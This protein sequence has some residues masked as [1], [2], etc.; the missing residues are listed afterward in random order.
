MN[1]IVTKISIKNILLNTILSIIK[2]TAGSFAGSLAVLSDGFNSL[3]DVATTITILISR[4]FTNK[5]SD[6]DHPYGHEKIESMVVFSVAIFLVAVALYTIYQSVL[7]LAG[8]NVITGSL[9]ALVASAFSAIVK[10]YMYHSTEKVAKEIDSDSLR[11]IAADYKFDVFLSMSVFVGVLF[12]MF[13]WWFFEPIAAIVA[14]VILFLSA[15]EFMK[16]AF[17]Q[18]V[19]KA[20]DDETIESIRK[21]VMDCNGVIRIDLIKTRLHGRFI[22]VDIEIS[23]DPDITVKS[24]HSIAQK[25]HDVIEGNKS[26]NVIH[27]NVH[28]NPFED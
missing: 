21:I 4:K 24:G 23:V 7:N 8:K 13:G 18:V 27:C 9:F 28:V 10:F 5:P 25:V 15:A 26:L 3:S 20:A 16:K 22:Y 12:T 2:V 17:N 6:T 14:S 19:D 11:I 1:D